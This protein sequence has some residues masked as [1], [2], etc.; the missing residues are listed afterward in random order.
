VKDPLTTLMQIQSPLQLQVDLRQ[1]KS[2]QKLKGLK[3]R[4]QEA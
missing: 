2:V 3:I 4:H 1:T